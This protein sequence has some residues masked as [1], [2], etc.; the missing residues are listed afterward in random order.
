MLAVVALL[1]TTA[2]GAPSQAPSLL[3]RTGPDMG[4]TLGADYAGSDYNITLWN[5]PAS[6]AA[7]NYKSSALA[8]GAYCAA[9]PKCCAWTYCPPGSGEE[10]EPFAISKADG[11]NVS[12]GAHAAALGERCC[13][14]KGVGVLRKGPEEAKH[15]TGLVPRAVKGGQITAQCKG[16]PLPPSPPPVPPG[17]KAWDGEC[18]A[19]YPGNVWQHPKI[20]Q[21]PDCL[22]IGGWHDMAGALTFVGVNG[23]EHHAFQGTH[24]HNT[25][26]QIHS[27]RGTATHRETHSSTQQHL[28]SACLSV[29]LI[30]MCCV[31]CYV[32]V[33]LCVLLLYAAVMLLYCACVRVCLCVCL[34]C[35]CVLMLLLALCCR[36]SGLPGLVSLCLQ[37]FG[38][39]PGSI[40]FP[41][42]A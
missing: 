33:V 4:P 24:T 27:S 9:D 1:A 38:A 6:K 37:R 34:L 36:V 23:L 35:V 11:W 2:A 41:R 15:W 18:I 25:Y 29:C 3:A 22:H 8:C 20:H 39:P 21:S 42:L 7:N 10:V 17:C 31:C 32:P 30:C 13:L 14:K 19:P 12:T 28:L 5:T 26:T 16:P 40:G